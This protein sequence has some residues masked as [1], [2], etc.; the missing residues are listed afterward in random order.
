MQIFTNEKLVAESLA[1]ELETRI[2]GEIS[3]NF[4]SLPL[5]QAMWQRIQRLEGEVQRLKNELRSRNRPS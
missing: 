5:L 3:M 1:E 4:W 2:P